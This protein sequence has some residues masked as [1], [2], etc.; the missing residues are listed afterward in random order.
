MMENDAPTKDVALLEG[1]DK[2]F[3]VAWGERRASWESSLRPEK[4]S[5]DRALMQPTISGVNFR[6][7]PLYVPFG[8]WRPFHTTPNTELFVFMFEG[9]MEWCV[10]PELDNLQRFRLGQYDSLF[11]PKGHG[12]IYGNIG[13]AEAKCLCGHARTGDE[14][15]KNIIWQLPGEAKPHS[16][17]LSGWKNE[18]ERK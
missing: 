10:G 11:V 5:W 1:K 3:V 6:F 9:E 17:D 13:P 16:H 14:W 12:V 8:R 15:P 18:P 7:A 2:P 4:V